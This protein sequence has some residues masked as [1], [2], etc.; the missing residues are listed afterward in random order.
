MFCPTGEERR[1]ARASPATTCL[2]EYVTAEGKRLNEG[3]SAAL[4]ENA[5][6]VGG[7]LWS[8]RQNFSLCFG[9]FSVLNQAVQ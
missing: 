4:F 6:W 8:F 1:P 9:G 5:I 3:L 7:R 2:T